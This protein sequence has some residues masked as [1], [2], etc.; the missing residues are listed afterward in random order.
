[1]NIEFCASNYLFITLSVSS[2]F[3]SCTCNQHFVHERRALPINLSL[4]LE[5]QLHHTMTSSADQM[6][7]MTAAEDGNNIDEDCSRRYCHSVRPA[8]RCL[9]GCCRR[10][11]CCDW[12]VGGVTIIILQISLKYLRLTSNINLNGHKPC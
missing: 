8:D 4:T 1:M 10:R 12:Q 9:I 6:T 2:C 7:S 5:A 11:F 3:I